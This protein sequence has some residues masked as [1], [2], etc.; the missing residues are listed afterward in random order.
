MIRIL[1]TSLLLAAALSVPSLAEQRSTQ[2][3]PNSRVAIIGDSITEQK[4]YSKYIETYL[5]ACT[6]RKDIKCFQFGWSGETASGFKMREENDLSVFQPNVATFCY[7]MNDGRYVPYAEAIGKDYEANMRADLIKAK[8][9]GVTN[10]VTGTPGAVDTKYF[11]KPS[12]TTAEQYNDNLAHLAALDRKLAEEFHTAFADVH[13]EMI[14]AMA[15]AKAA[16]GPDYD[17]C[18][19]D[20]VHP[21]PNGHLLMAAAYLKGLGLDGNIGEITVDMKGASAGSEGHHVTGE[22]GNAFAESTQWPFCFEGDDKSPGGTRSILP[23]CKFNDELNRFTLK[24]KNLDAAKA[25]VTWETETREFTKEQ[26]AKGINLPAEFKTTP[27]DHAFFAFM[28]GVRQ[29]Q[30]FET[31]MIK[32][33]ITNFRAF[34]ADAKADP[35]FGSALSVLKKKLLSKQEALDEAARKLLVTVRHTIKVEAVK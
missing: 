17:V 21:G 29:K 33:M 26:L 28:N 13:K 11:N 4:L 15:K 35:E 8:E 22:N 23:Y 20:G 30:E 10:I 25:K 2:L 6:G 16:F 34:T 9:M 14:D 5:L 19:R 3:P 32:A 27:F 31:P 18:G 12:G 7:G 1:P 24:V